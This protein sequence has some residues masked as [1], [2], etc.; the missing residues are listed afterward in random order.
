MIFRGSVYSQMLEMKTAVSVLFPNNFRKAWPEPAEHPYRVVYLLHGLVGNN[1]NWTDYTMLPYFAQDTHTVFIM[2]DATRSY[3]CDQK[4]GQKYFS[5]VC[6]ELPDIAKR[7]FNISAKREETAV[8]G[9]SMGG[10]GA[11]KAGLSRPDFFGTIG[12]IAPALLYFDEFL[13]MLKNADETGGEIGGFY[14]PQMRR[15]F[16]AILGPELAWDP[17]CEI[18]ELVKKAETQKITPRIFCTCGSEDPLVGFNLRFRD[19]MK[20]SK[21]DFTYEEAE[22]RHD[23]DFFNT[24]LKKSVEFFLA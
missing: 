24:G 21:L 17:N 12:A 15:D 5:Y 1:A 23:W 19:E 13:T 3:Y 7:L 22:G 8:I 11:L 14:T 20:T 4:Y 18:M 6:H 16:E 10:Y 2:P 9:C